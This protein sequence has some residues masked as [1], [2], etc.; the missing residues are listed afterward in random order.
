MNNYIGHPLQISGVTEVTLSN[1]KGKG[2]TLLQ[3]AN[4][5]GMEITLSPDRCLDIAKITYKGDNM[6]YFAPCGYVSAEHYDKDGAGFLK[7]FNAGF[8][9][10]CGL[11]AVGSPCTDNGE[12]LPLHGNI[13]N[14]PCESYYYTEDD[15]KINVVGKIRDAVL[16]G[17]SYVLT[18]TYTISKLSNTFSVSDN[19]KNVGNTL[20][21]CMLLYHINL[22]YPL[23]CE[24]TN[25]YIPHTSSKARNDHAEETF[26]Q[27]LV[28]QKPTP[29]YEE[30]CYY[31]DVKQNG[32]YASV[33][34]YNP[35]INKGV[36]ISFDK[37]T[38][39]CFTQWKMMGVREY[40]LGL[41]P[42]NCYP[43]GRDVMRKQGI[44][45]ELKPNEEYN[46]QIK[47]EFSQKPEDIQCL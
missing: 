37:S 41:E 35:D 10:T 12:T 5:K 28:M 39:D 25:V 32:N 47:V 18:R 42:G 24:N 17:N 11:S 29:D 44:L 9:T 15:D 4:G 8:M 46:T 3:I 20:A 36:K 14:T 43:D 38:L 7:S 30:C 26:D 34:A 27:K 19:V 33:G 21:P 6:G 40:V 16:F 22:G 13:S 23:L 2:M 45:K 31:Y 1:G